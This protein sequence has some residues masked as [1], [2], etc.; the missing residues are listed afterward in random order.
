VVDAPIFARVN[1]YLKA[2]YFDFG[3]H[4]KG[5]Q[6]LAQIEAPELDASYT[7]AKARLANSKAVV[8][9]REAELEFAKTTY[10]RW[11][12]S[13][14]GVVSVQETQAK[15]GDFDSA[16]ARLNALSLM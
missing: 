3:A 16:T 13:P 4:V 12:N 11:R 7:A 5:G 1:G 9:V 8:N 2:W 6:V 10:E 15:K 14:K